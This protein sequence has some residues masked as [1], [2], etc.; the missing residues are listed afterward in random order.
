MLEVP[1]LLGPGPAGAG[2]GRTWRWGRSA[3]A[4]LPDPGERRQR[5]GR[6]QRGVNKGPQR[7]EASWRRGF[8][9][10]QAGIGPGRTL[11][12]PARVPAPS[13]PPARSP[14]LAARGRPRRSW[15]GGQSPGRRGRG[16]NAEPFAATAI[17]FPLSFSPPRVRGFW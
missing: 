7:R 12:R 2:G 15:P 5:N 11:A 14:T 8:D 17:P 6:L 10:L 16:H 4:A 9:G 1:L 13:P 3:P